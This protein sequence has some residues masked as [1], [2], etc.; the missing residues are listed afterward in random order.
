M[1]RRLT[2][3]VLLVLACGTALAASPYPFTGIIDRGVDGGVR[4][5]NV[6]C[7][8]GNPGT[9]TVNVKSREICVQPYAQAR[10]CSPAWTLNDAA[11]RACGA[12]R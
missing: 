12:G 10:Q 8:A 9:M 11:A 7:T 3:A 5:Y 2:V 4:Y 6:Q 1:N